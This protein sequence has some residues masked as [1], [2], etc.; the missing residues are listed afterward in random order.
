[1]V[2]GFFSSAETS[3][4]AL[5]RY[6]LRHLAQKGHRGAI[7]ASRLLERPD[8]LLGLILLGNNLVNIAAASLATLI[9]LRTLGEAGVALA[10]GLLTLVILIFA[11]VAPK[12]LAALHPERIAFPAAWALTILMAIFRPLVIAIAKVANGSL[13]LLGIK[14]HG[15]DRDAL[16]RDELRTVVSE[17]GARIPLSHKQM[18]IGILDLERVAVNDIMIPRDEIEAIDLDAPPREILE[19]IR[20]AEHTRIPLYRGNINE[21]FGVLHIKKAIA[22]P[23]DDGLP[24][25]LEERA[26]EASFAPVGTPLGVQ[27]RNFQRSRNHL[28]LIVDELGDIEGL[29]TIE[30][31]LEEIVGEFSTEPMKDVQVEA[32]GS[33]LVDGLA[34]IR[35][36]NREMQ[37]ELPTDGPKTL[38][39]LLLEHFETIPEPGTSII[40]A[41]YPFK[42]IE[43]TSK[44]VRSARINPARRQKPNP[45]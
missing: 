26:K 40:I 12:T 7:L 28:W 21:I 2:S 22:A 33:Y 27:L 20:S 31:L 16:S 44:G 34:N 39:G 23:N 38:N 14:I 43:T 29:L 37:W 19:R 17:A 1:M 32:D 15:S 42:I 10:A 6:R 41:G 4:M 5:S 35:D 25:W 18:L 45:A 30:D 9:A 3:M 11:E 36:I 13:W 24:A 8:R